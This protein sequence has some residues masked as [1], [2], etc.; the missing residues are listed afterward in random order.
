MATEVS[1]RE[2]ASVRAL[3]RQPYSKSNLLISAKRFK[4]F[5]KGSKRMIH[6]KTQG[7]KLHLMHFNEKQ[8][9]N[10]IK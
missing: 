1:E 3:T 5:K 10:I 8:A 4:Q 6:S 9:K 7:K 2:S